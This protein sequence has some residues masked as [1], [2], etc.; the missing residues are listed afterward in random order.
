MSAAFAGCL[1]YFPTQDHISLFAVLNVCFKIREREGFKSIPMPSWLS[2]ICF[3]A[4]QTLINYIFEFQFHKSGH[5]TSL[6]NCNQQIFAH[7]FILKHIFKKNSL[8]SSS[9]THLKYPCIL[10]LLS[11]TK[12][13]LWDI[14]FLWDITLFLK[15]IYLHFS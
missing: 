10:M 11:F 2:Y 14:T 6:Q 13:R 1:Q 9:S 8:R 12:I 5:F 7:I 15:H 3:I 4:I